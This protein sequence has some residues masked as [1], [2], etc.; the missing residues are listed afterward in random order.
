MTWILFNFMLYIVHTTQIKLL[1]Q[2]SKGPFSLNRPNM[3]LLL[4]VLA[5][6]ASGF[7]SDLQVWRISASLYALQ[8]RKKVASFKSI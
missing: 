5:A 4:A 6:V 3:L 8:V 2:T 7:Y 1:R